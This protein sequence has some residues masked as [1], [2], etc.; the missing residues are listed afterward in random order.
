M[1]TLLWLVV[2]AADSMSAAVA[3]RAGFARERL[4]SRRE[5]L[6]PLLLVQVAHKRI[7]LVRATT[8]LPH[9]LFL[10]QPRA[11]AVA[12]I[13]ILRLGLAGRA[14]AAQLTPAER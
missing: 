2:A 9:L 7:Q 12:Q 8:A 4:L 6:T 13:L 10:F 3:V 5:R 1:N 11:A 14:V